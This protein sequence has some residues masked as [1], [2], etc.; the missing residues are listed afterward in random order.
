MTRLWIAVWACALWSG[1]AAAQDFPSRPVR[2][3][4]PFPPGGSTD[5]VARAIQPGFAQRLGQTV[6]IEHKPG[7][8]SSIG[9][10]MVARAPADGHTIVLVSPNVVV[11]PHL[12]K[13]AFDPMKDLQPI[14]QAVQSYYILVAN[15]AL[16]ARSM[17]E[18]VAL[19]KA[20]PGKLT[21]GSWGLGAHSHLAGE[22]LNRAAGVA[23]VHVPYKGSVLALADVM[24]GQISMMFDV[25]STSLPQ[26]RAGKVRAIA[27][28]GAQRSPQLPEVPTVGETLPGYSVEGWL[29]FL[30]PAGTPGDVVARLQRDITASLREPAVQQRLQDAGYGMGAT[31]TE[32]FARL[33]RSDY[34]KYGQLIRER[35]IKAE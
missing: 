16:P 24:G 34:E 8:G 23:T 19:A 12:Y 29:G 33:L 9:L 35:G 28:A 2:L 21:Y 14:T 25:L 30:A 7:A 31:P 26:I 11:N 20:Q 3:V 5:I 1:L 17:A 22:L 18:L 13:L 15:P 4:V 6:V 10:E 32:E 27:V